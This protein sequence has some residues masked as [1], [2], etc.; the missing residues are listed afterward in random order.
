MTIKKYNQLT[1]KDRKLIEN[2]IENSFH[3]KLTDNY[4]K[5]KFEFAIID[6]LNRGLIILQ[7][8]G[9][10]MYL[11]KFAVSKQFQGKGVGKELFQESL[12]ISNGKLFWRCNPK[13]PIRK[14]YSLIVEKNNGGF[15]EGEDW[16]IYWT[17]LEKEEI[18][19]CIKYAL[20]KEKTLITL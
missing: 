19:K 18:P 13:N 15:F 1:E 6:N 9:S 14:W 4:F 8:Q 16:I 5:S 12:K 17:N 3:R 7:K 20:K 10:A 2:I 11:D